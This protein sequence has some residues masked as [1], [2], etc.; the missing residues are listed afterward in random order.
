MPPR[1]TPAQRRVL[2]T[3][4]LC[5]GVLLV[6]GG[7]GKDPAAPPR[8]KTAEPTP[9][10]RLNSDGLVLARV[11]FCPLVPAAAVGDALG[12]SGPVTKQTWRNGDRADV[13]D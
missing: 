10:S 6:L 5:L 13:E 11:D 8:P 2:G 7:C 3:L 9:I 12:G 4:V 1:T